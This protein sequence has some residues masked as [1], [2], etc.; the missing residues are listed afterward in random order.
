MAQLGEY[1]WLGTKFKY[2]INITAPGFSMED[3]DFTVE[4]KR[5]SKSRVFQKD[6]LVEDE[7]GNYYVCFDSKEFGPG[8]I[9]AVITAHVPD[10]DFDDGIRDEVFKVDLI[11]VKS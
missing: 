11:Y 9:S 10:D 3:D 1:G 6:D 2:A 5:G 8:Q 4:I 7:Q